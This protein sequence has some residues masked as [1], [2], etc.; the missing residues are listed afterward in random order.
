MQTAH[1]DATAT[2]PT[3]TDAPTADRLG[4]SDAVPCCGALLAELSHDLKTPLHGILSFAEIG[5]GRCESA[6]PEKLK[7]YFQ[8]IQEAGQ[9][10]HRALEDLIAIG[11]LESGRATLQPRA[12]DVATLLRVQVT[13]GAPES[14]E[15]SIQFAVPS[16]AP[17]RVWADEATLSRALLAILK[18]TLRRTPLGGAM[19]FSVDSEGDW[20]ILRATDAGPPMSDAE[21]D[22]LFVHARQSGEAD[23]DALACLGL[24]LA[25]AAFAALGG[26][27]RAR[28]ADNGGVTIEAG[29]PACSRPHPDAPH[30]ITA[31]ATGNTA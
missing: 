26:W 17:A 9:A 19:R 20:V 11:K 10:L 31:P 14:S 15:R 22:R 24:V 25:R 2:H 6:P 18:F 30:A 28:H 4:S 7:G 5:L 8:R 29:L 16:A 12:V 13:E 27:V 23:H 1:Q 3:A 21:L